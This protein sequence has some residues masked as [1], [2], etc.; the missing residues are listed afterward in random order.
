MGKGKDRGDKTEKPT[1]KKL[2]DARKKGDV[3]KSKDVGAA[4]TTLT[5]C[6]LFAVAIGYGA[7][8][9]A[10]FARQSV[11]L[12]TRGEF[13]DQ[14]DRLGSRALW[15]MLGLSAMILV[16]LAAIGLAIEFLQT[17]PILTGEKIKPSLD[18]LNPV[19]GL[20]RMFGKDGL[21]ELAKTLLKV[22]ALSVV[23]A[24]VFMTTLETLGGLTRQ[25]LFSETANGGVIAG[26]RTAVYFYSVTLQL[27]IC[28]AFLFLAIAMIDRIHQQHSFM[29]KMQMSRR[30]IK[31]EH[32]NEEGDPMVRSERRQMHQQWAENNA[33]RATARSSAL[34]V[35]PTHIAIAL[36]HD[37]EK[38]PIPVVAA[39][40]TGP[41]AQLMR[42]VARAEGVPIIRNVM[43]ARSLS[44]RC[45]VGEMVPEDMFEAIAEIILWA[46]KAKANEAP[47]EQDLGRE[48][49]AF[50]ETD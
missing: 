29:K 23:T 1:P 18:K 43:A 46:R 27:L 25:A 7:S 4:F 12:A 14:A 33:A 9:V 17:G 19:E 44:A 28:C 47:M 16:P 15:L 26:E 21:V 39:K 35:N 37:P 8:L 24:I 6:L 2:R 5:F 40:G 42:E 38:A 31:Q 20:K 30:D 13:L 32:K 11:E 48:P 34:L 3:A 45:E 50:E 49:M 41:L 36:D 10:D 22:I